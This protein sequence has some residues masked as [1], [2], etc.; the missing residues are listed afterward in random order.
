MCCLGSWPQRCGSPQISIYSRPY[1]VTGSPPPQK[2][3]AECSIFSFISAPEL[4][5]L[6]CRFLYGD[7]PWTAQA[8]LV[9]VSHNTHSQ[10]NLPF[11]S[12]NHFD[13]WHT[14]FKFCTFLRH[15][16]ITSRTDFHNFTE[17]SFWRD[18]VTGWIFFWKS[19]LFNQCFLCM[20][21]WLQGLQKLFTTP[22]NC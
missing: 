6:N 22:Y 1:Y 10:Y 12:R 13:F 4:F 17:F 20:H 3:T 2:K 5:H 16:P 15:V 18:T 19:Q 9:T 8:V 7:N 21:W 11:H 14:P